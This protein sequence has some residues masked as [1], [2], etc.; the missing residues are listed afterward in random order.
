MEITP[1]VGILRALLLLA[2]IT[3]LTS[4]ATS[5]TTPPPARLAMAQRIQAE[6][7]GDYFIGRRYFKS[8]YRFWGYIRRPG[9]P[10]NSA[11]LVMLNENKM[12]APDRSQLGPGTGASYENNAGFDNDYEYKLTGYFS[13]D[14][15][16][17]LVSNRTYP[18]FVLTGY[19]LLSTR[20]PPIFQSQIRR[21]RVSPFAIEKP[22]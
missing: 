22:E 19:T 14:R 8:N 21:H 6:P 13:G 7:P 16:Y 4:C 9:R 12:L 3:G 11:V 5:A 10:W 2:A 15:I 20:P 1:Q 17:E 18:E